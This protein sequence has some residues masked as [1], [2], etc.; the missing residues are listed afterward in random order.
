VPDQYGRP[1]DSSGPSGL[2]QGQ[3]TPSVPVPDL[4]SRTVVDG[5]GTFADNAIA[6]Q[7]G[8][9]VKT[10]F[11]VPFFSLAMPIAIL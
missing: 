5:E 2:T 9:D 4:G 11:N 10:A 1:L 3:G 7:V 6:G 8:I